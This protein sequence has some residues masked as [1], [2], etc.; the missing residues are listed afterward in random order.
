MAGRVPEPPEE[1][2]PP[3]G[4]PETGGFHYPETPE[5]RRAWEREAPRQPADDATRYE[6]PPPAG[7]GT[8]DGAEPAAERFRRSTRARTR[9]IPDLP[10]RGYWG[11]ATGT[12]L[13]VMVVGSVGDYTELL[14]RLPGHVVFW[15]LVGLGALASVHRERRN[16]W[17]SAAR[18][19]WPTAAVAGSVVAEVLALNVG[20]VAVITGSLIVLGLGLFVLVLVE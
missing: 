16:E 11:L 14:G 3:A 6:A 9:P 2:L 8:D 15:S 7:S 13:F 4:K 1:G 5:A 12:V 20:S 18:W 17:Q 19:P 10:K